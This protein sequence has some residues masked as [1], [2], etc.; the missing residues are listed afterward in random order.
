MNVKKDLVIAGF[1]FS[2]GLL[3]ADPNLI[4]QLGKTDQS[5]LDFLIPYRAWEY[6]N[7]PE[8]QRAKEM[9]HKT[10]TFHYT[11]KEN[12]ITPTPRIVR[13]LS[14][15]SERVWMLKDEMV[16]NLNLKWN[17]EEGGRRDRA[18]NVRG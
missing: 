10:A 16:C 18:R 14:S 2:A 4:W 6:G 15:V 12:G 5:D 1:L 7:A 11:V 9:D 8:I 17:E 3:A 13:A